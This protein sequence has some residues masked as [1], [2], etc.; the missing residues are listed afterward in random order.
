MTYDCNSRGPIY[1]VPYLYG[2]NTVNDGFI[3]KYLYNAKKVKRM[4]FGSDNVCEN[5]IATT[6]L[7]RVLVGGFEFFG[8]PGLIIGQAD[9]RQNTISQARCLYHERHT[10]SCVIVPCLPQRI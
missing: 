5:E 7:D 6:I 4:L 8:V 9:S 10:T 1:H 3:I 2:P